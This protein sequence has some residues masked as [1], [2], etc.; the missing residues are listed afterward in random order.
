[1]VG[2]LIM[3]RS[4]CKPMDHFCSPY[5][6]SQVS[7][8]HL[9]IRVA[10]RAS[11]PLSNSYTIWECFASCMGEP[12]VWVCARMCVC[13]PVLRDSAPSLSQEGPIPLSSGYHCYLPVTGF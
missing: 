3:H 1:M 4:L 13:P 7:D 11:C 12:L 8:D 10:K 6:E 2:K 5:G 9:Q